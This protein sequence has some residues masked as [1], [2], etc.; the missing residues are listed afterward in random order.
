[1]D[2]P[3]TMILGT[4]ERDQHPLAEAAEHVEAA[5]D[6]PEL[7]DGFGADRMQQRR[8][9]WIEHIANMVVGGDFDD[10]EQVGAVGAAMPFLEL[11][12]MRQERR[13]LH[14]KHREG[15]HSDVAHAVGR[16]HAATLVRKPVQ[17][18]SK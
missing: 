11:P 6:P 3:G 8:G 7:L 5:V 9:G 14:E 17:A 2:I 18:I 13:A 16:V 12:L 1:M 4:V 10:A 15:R